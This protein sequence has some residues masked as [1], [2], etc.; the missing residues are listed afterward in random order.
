MTKYRNNMLSNWLI[1]TK[2]SKS[3]L[4]VFPLTHFHI[5]F[6]I[7]ITHQHSPVVHHSKRPSGCKID[8]WHKGI[9]LWQ[10][11]RTTSSDSCSPLRE[12]ETSF[13]DLASSAIQFEG[14][15]FIAAA[16][17][18]CFR[19]PASRIHRANIH[20]GKHIAP[21]HQR[22]RNQCCTCKAQ[23]HRCVHLPLFRHDLPETQRRNNLGSDSTSFDETTY[24]NCGFRQSHQV[25]QVDEV[26]TLA[27]ELRIWTIR[28]SPRSRH[29]RCRL[30]GRNNAGS[31][32]AP[33]E[34]SGKPS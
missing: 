11:I 32:S 31:S 3:P 27:L 33:F 5:L 18:T 15:A 17:I 12:N 21:H 8:C 20:H 14:V 30:R 34:Q 23:L 19:I 24:C 28:N 26:S 2:R 7:F 10:R 16:V 13:K 22:S 25:T 9:R 6:P 29:E 4:W 1:E